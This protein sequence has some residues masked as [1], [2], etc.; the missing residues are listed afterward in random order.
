MKFILAAGLTGML[1]EYWY[2]IFPL[3]LLAIGLLVWLAIVI[4]RAVMSAKEDS[5][6]RKAIMQDEA[7]ERKRARE[8]ADREKE[9]KEKALKEQAITLEESPAGENISADNAEE[10]GGAKTAE[11][12]SKEKAVPKTK[13]AEIYADEETIMETEEK[14]TEKKAIYRVIYDGENKE[15]MIKKDGAARV[16]RR[17]KT[18]AEALELAKKFAENQDLS[19]N[20]HKKDGKFQKKGNY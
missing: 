17:V 4:Y 9:D 8:K 3:T 19:L 14:K 20:V 5:D 2:I 7:N 11:K 6:V 12:P 18:K 13:G 10:K 16:I 15:W 1:A